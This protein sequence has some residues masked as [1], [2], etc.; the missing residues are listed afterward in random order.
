MYYRLWLGSGIRPPR[1]IPLGPDFKK[2]LYRII[3]QL[4]PQKRQV[5]LLKIEKG[6]TN[7][8]V[9]EYMNISVPTVKSHYTQVIK[10]LRAKIADIPILL[11]L[12]S[13][14]YH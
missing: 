2:Y 1:T 12:M 9:A 4:P 11:M 7:Q 14:V 13:S 3:D 5:C 6:M 8:E 10:L